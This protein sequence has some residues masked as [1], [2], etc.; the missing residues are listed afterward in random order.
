MFFLYPKY[1]VCIFCIEFYKIFSF[2]PTKFVDINEI[3]LGKN[4]RN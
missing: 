4:F 2:L 3:R 1:V